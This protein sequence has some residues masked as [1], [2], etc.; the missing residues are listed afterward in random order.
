MRGFREVSH[1]ADVKIEAYGTDF[2]EALIECVRGFTSMVTELATL[3]EAEERAL[4]LTASS[5]DALLYDLI[6]ELIYRKDVEAFLA[7]S[8]R[9]KV[10]HEKS[11]WH[12]TGVLLGR[13]LYGHQLADVKAMTYHDLTIDEQPHKT[14]I[15]YV[16][17]L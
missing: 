8:A 5:K 1:T 17:D 11:T 3:D 7:S 4:A 16:L 2:T 13:T 12:L 15:T 14:T 6:T 10:W 9:I